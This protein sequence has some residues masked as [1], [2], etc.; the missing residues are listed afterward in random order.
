M[1]EMSDIAVYQKLTEVA[2]ELEQMATEDVTFVGGAALTTAASTVRG[3]ASAVYQ[4]IM[5][6]RD[7]GLD[8]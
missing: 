1:A 4:R 3:M 8:S 7:E 2:D 5:A 6:D